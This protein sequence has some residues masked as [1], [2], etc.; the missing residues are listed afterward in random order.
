MRGVLASGGLRG[1]SSGRDGGSA[2]EGV[3]PVAREV[4]LAE[5]KQ[6]KE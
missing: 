2:S 4:G 3:G 5:L 6:W 1:C